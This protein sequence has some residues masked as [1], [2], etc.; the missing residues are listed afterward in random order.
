M[1]SLKNYRMLKKMGFG[2][3]FNLKNTHHFCGAY[4]FVCKWIDFVLKLNFI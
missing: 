3:G 4:F 2:K 1:V